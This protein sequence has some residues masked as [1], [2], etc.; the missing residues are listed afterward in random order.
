MSKDSMFEPGV[1]TIGDKQVEISSYSQL[2]ELRKNSVVISVC[3]VLDGMLYNQ[4]GV[5]I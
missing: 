2:L 3:C 4:L 5:G 1:F